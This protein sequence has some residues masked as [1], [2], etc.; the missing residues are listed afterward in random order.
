MLF[1]QSTPPNKTSAGKKT[2]ADENN[3]IDI[4][5]KTPSTKQQQ[6][7]ARTENIEGKKQLK[8]A[9]ASTKQQTSGKGRLLTNEFSIV[10]FFLSR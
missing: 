6:G 8:T 10:H 9:G 1:I 3:K 2:T 4:A 7:P 5:T